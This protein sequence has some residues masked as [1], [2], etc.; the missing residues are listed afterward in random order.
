MPPTIR[1]RNGQTYRRKEAPALAEPP[2]GR[3]EDAA[4]GIAG[5]AWGHMAAE[6][7]EKVSAV[8]GACAEGAGEVT[9]P[10]TGDEEARGQAVID[11]QDQQV[12]AP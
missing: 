6:V 3:A 1:E 8:I 10:P 12:G 9:A 4:S 5:V 7:N 11:T 2:A